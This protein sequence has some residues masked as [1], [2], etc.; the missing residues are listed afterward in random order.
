[1]LGACASAPPPV[2]T[3]ASPPL[4]AA[5]TPEGYAA[6]AL[7]ASPPLLP[8]GVLVTDDTARYPVIGTTAAE[9]GRQLGV[10]RE[11]AAETEYIGLTATN[12]RWQFRA[13]RSDSGCGLVRVAVLLG[14]TT[15]LPQ[16]LPPSGTPDTLAR[17]WLTFL[18]ATRVHERGHRN[19]ALHTAVDILRTLSDVRGATCDGLDEVANLNAHAVWDLGHRRQIAYDV[20]TRHGVTQGSQWPPRA[21]DAARESRP[22]ESRE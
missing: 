11:D 22:T 6:L 5:I 14:V 18:A 2:R 21:A 9:L 12:V 20:A 19:I 15:T 1:M 7:A 8:A 16:W 3:T 13:Q 17:Q 4:V 10:D